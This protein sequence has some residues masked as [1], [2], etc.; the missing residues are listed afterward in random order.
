MSQ[1]SYLC[2]AL[3]SQK[4]KVIMSETRI[5]IIIK[6]LENQIK[7][8]REQERFYREENPC[9]TLQRYHEGKADAYQKVLNLLSK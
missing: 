8:D 9:A 5:K 4:K 1:V 2:K 3:E 6:S 7:M